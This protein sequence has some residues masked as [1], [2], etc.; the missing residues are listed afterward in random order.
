M[1]RVSRLSRVAWAALCALLGV[2]T[3]LPAA[4]ADL[5]ARDIAILLF[6]SAPGSHPSLNNRNLARLDLAGLNFK[7]ADLR[8]ANLFGSDLTD[9]DLSGTDL[10]GARL[11]RVTLIGAR[12]DVETLDGASM[13]RPSTSSTL[14]PRHNEEQSFK[15]DSWRRVK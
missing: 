6:H 10:T 15:G 4:A 11:D 12:L 7:Q 1:R 9:A 3:L 14:K 5:T 2:S 13:L 8:Q